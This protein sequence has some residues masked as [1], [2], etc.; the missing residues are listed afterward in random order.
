VVQDFATIHS[1]S[2]GQKK[3]RCFHQVKKMMLKS[4]FNG[5]GLLGQRYTMFIQMVFQIFMASID[6]KKKTFQNKSLI[7]ARKCSG[8]F[9]DYKSV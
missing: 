9:T 5:Q 4:H 3:K 1:I 7:S 6:H 8:P 2:W